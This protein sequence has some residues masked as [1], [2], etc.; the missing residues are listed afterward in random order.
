MGHGVMGNHITCMSNGMA[1]VKGFLQ[2]QT[3]LTLVC[4][5]RLPTAT[6]LIE[7]LHDY[8]TYNLPRLL[9]VSVNHPHHRKCIEIHD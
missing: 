7:D 4:A 5:N 3:V 6:S 2:A 8:V 1:C 9:M